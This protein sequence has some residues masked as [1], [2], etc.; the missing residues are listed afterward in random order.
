MISSGSASSSSSISLCPDLR[1][2]WKLGKLKVSQQYVL[3]KREGQYHLPLSEIEGFALQYFTG[4]YSIERVQRLCEQ[5]FRESIS[6]D[7]VVELL[8]KLE[9]LGVVGKAEGKEDKGDQVLSTNVTPEKS[10]L[11]PEVQW[12]SH[13]DGHWILRNRSDLTFLQVNDVGKAVTDDLGR[14]SPDEIAAKHNLSPGELQQHLKLLAATG[15][16][17]GT[18]PQ[19]AKKGKFTP[20]NLL[21]FLLPLF[22]PDAWLSKHLGKVQW[23]FTP[24]FAWGLLAFLAYSTVVGLSQQEAIAVFGLKLWQGSD[25]SLI[26]AFVILSLLVVSLHEL[27]HAFTLKHYGGIVPEMGVMFMCLFPAAYTDTTDS[28]CLVK[29]RQRVLVVAV[30]VLCQLTIATIALGLWNLTVPGSWLHID[31][32]LLLVAA[33]FTVA[34]NLNPLAKFDGYYLAV[35]ATGINNLRSRSFQFY[36]KLLTSQPIEEKPRDAGILALY[37]PLSLTY[38]WLVFGFL[39]CRLG[40]WLLTNIP[41]LA[42]TLL[43]LWGIYY[44]F[45]TE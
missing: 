1:Q 8:V 40:D 31:S 32:Y 3:Q 44:F 35:A 9:Q 30:G 28:Y 36:L 42:L 15:M 41:F 4:S 25:S 26:L 21:F 6:S 10:P 18:E 22:N 45:P 12:F 43:V 7:F 2:G 38:L 14:L 37:A 11:K 16:L 29:R 20:F 27:A 13:P 5:Q 17:I 34:V 39:F 23:L 24:I 19:K 33:L